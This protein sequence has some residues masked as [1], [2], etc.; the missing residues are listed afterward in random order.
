MD[1]AREQQ[2][3]TRAQPWQDWVKAELEARKKA[4]ETDEGRKK[5]E[6]LAKAFIRKNDED[7]NEAYDTNKAG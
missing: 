6:E 7:E 5:Q 2:E 4:D 1:S 3:D